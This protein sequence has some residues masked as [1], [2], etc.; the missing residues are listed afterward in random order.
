[1][2]EEEKLTFSDIVEMIKFALTMVFLVGSVLFLGAFIVISVCEMLDS[3]TENTYDAVIV[4]KYKHTEGRRTDYYVTVL[5]SDDTVHEFND[6]NYFY[7]YNIG[8]NVKVRT[9]IYTGMKNM[10][11]KYEILKE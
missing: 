4:D 1:M 6:I 9:K 8:D 2:E 7:V 10:F 5:M 3:G 11:N